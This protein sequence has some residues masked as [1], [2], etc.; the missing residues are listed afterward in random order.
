[1]NSQFSQFSSHLIARNK[2]PDEH[3]SKCGTKWK[4]TTY[5]IITFGSSLLRVWVFLSSVC[6]Q[7]GDLLTSSDLFFF[8][9]SWDSSC[10]H[11]KLKTCLNLKKYCCSCCCY[12]CYCCC[13]FFFCFFCFF[14]CFWRRRIKG[15]EIKKGVAW[16]YQ[17]REAQE[18]EEEEERWGQQQAGSIRFDLSPV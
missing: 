5:D 11:R 6:H 7:R 10:L 3:S 18:E 2:T 15:G 9:H 14:L 17:Q 8:L 12:C 13:C 1:M 4:L 16:G